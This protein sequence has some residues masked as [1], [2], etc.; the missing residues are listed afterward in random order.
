[1][2][3]LTMLFAMALPL[4][5][6][7]AVTVED[8]N[9][10]LIWQVNNPTKPSAAHLL[11]GIPAKKMLEFTHA[12]GPIHIKT[13]YLKKIDT[14]CAVIAVTYIIERTLTKNGE[15][16]TYAQTVP[17]IT[18]KDGSQPTIQPNIASLS[19]MMDQITK[20]EMQPFIQGVK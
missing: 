12:L 18:C 5:S 1:M 2:R 6:A 8:L 16:V 14:K 13:S 7:Y 15:R 3:L 11:G 4:S 19:A 17:N 9:D 20:A 10:M